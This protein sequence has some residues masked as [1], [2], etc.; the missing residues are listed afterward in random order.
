MA[1]DRIPGV[2]IAFVDQGAI[3]WKKTYG[4]ANLATLERVNDQTVFTGASLSKSL[5]A[6]A[7]LCLVEQGMLDLDEDVNIKLQG[8]QVP[9]NEFT[10]NE[11][12][13]L[14]RLISHRAGIKNIL[15]SSFA[16]D[17]VVPT[18]EQMLAGQAPSTEPPVSL[19]A[20]PGEEEKYSNPGYSIVQ[21]LLN[22]VSGERFE[23]LL[24]RLVLKPSG[25]VDSSFEQPMPKRLKARRA[26]GYDSRLKPYS[27]KLFPYKAAGGVWTTPTDIANFMIALFKDYE[28][29]E[30]M[31]TKAMMAQV[32][33]R[34]PERLG[35]SKIFQDGSEDLV[36]RH[37]GSNQGFTC[38][39]V[40]SLQHKQAV[41]IMTNSDNGFN[42]L[43]YIARAV[44]EYCGWDYLKPTEYPPI[45][46]AAETM[47]KY[48]G[49]FDHDSGKLTF[50]VTDKALWVA[51]ESTGERMKLTPVGERKFIDP[52]NAMTYEFFRNRTGEIKYYK[53]ARVIEPAGREYWAPKLAQQP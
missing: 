31:L 6:M 48:C 13:T 14:R 22:D 35:F 27:Y 38:Y 25:M 12:V 52:A 36:F 30:I 10:K 46:L 34:N 47:A 3:A 24:D 28:G 4:Y 50:D 33:S 32:F 1:E 16:P 23:D 53:W 20:V 11:K 37:Y 17:E 45:E 51:S 21:K 40:G 42:L 29:R 5:T 43:D 19:E 8:W 41:I 7:A 44:A 15:W 49:S 18:L 26:I 39:M 2:S 9:D